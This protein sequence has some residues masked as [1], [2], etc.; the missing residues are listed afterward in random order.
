MVTGLVVLLGLY[1]LFLCGCVHVWHKHGIEK[2]EAD[3]NVDISVI[4]CASNEEETIGVLLDELM[5]QICRAKEII[6]VDDG[7]VDRTA[8]IVASFPTVKLIRTSGIGKKRALKLGVEAATCDLIACTDA[9]CS[10]SPTWLQAIASSFATYNPSLIIAPVCMTADHTCWQQLQAVEFLSL[11]A[12]TTGSALLDHPTMCNGAN[13]AFRREVWLQ[14]FG[15]LKMEEPS[16]DD[17]FFMM[18]C[19]K[20]GESIRYLKSPEAMVTIKP[21]E[22]LSQFVNQRRRWISKSKSYND[23][24]TIVLAL[25]T[26]LVTLAPVFLM[27]TGHLLPGLLFWCAKTV[28]DTWFVG[29]FSSFFNTQPRMTIVLLL[30]VIYPF[31]VCY[32][33]VSGLFCK[34]H[35]K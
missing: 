27:V 8:E 31:Y 33:A 25:I 35:W 26:F 16:G 19:K 21:N 10:V 13:L 4:V 24:E 23:I 15:D 30:A 1:V 18:Y 6:V 3:L 11:A 17:M 22:T 9:D 29:C 14:S 2:T 34:V 7:S 12:V 32:V 28:A 20:Q 5:L